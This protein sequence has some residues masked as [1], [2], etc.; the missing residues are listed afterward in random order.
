MPDSSPFNNRILLQNII[1]GLTVSFVA[2]SLGAAFGLLSGRGAFSG[3]LSAALIAS[4]TALFGGTRVQCS[5]PTGPMTAVTAVIFAAAH[6]QIPE[7]IPVL[8][9]DH[10]INITIILM[11]GLLFL[12]SILRLGKFI[13]FVPVVVVSGFM[14]G[15]ALII[16][17]DQIKKLFGLGG[18]A[19][20]SGPVSQNALLMVVSAAL[21]FLLPLLT[22]KFLPKLASYLSATIISIFVTTLF[23]YAV[24]F[25]VERVQLSTSLKGFSDITEL[26]SA[27]FPSTWSSTIIWYALPFA[28]QLALLCYLDTL[29]TSLVVDKMTEEKTRPNRELAAQGL[30]GF[31]VAFFGGIPG[32]QATIRSVLI[33]KEHATL[34]LAGVLVGVFALIEMILFQDA[35]NLIPQS[36]FAGILMKVGYDVFDWLPLRLYLKE[37]FRSPSVAVHGFFN[38]HDDK[39]I[40]ITNRE[41]L[42]ILGTSVVTIAWNLNAAVILFTAVFYVHNKLVNRNNPMRDLRPL[43]ETDVFRDTGSE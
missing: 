20:F 16:W 41:M 31:V 1:A 27:Q 9:P 26:V 36:V 10:F 18:K 28:F 40:F 14:N 15:I 8:N 24:G 34:R 35:I 25:D 11:A 29:L 30:A 23:A 37:V 22:R 38:R 6:D 19:A 3:M 33:V 32:A 4:I 17:F 12:F 13:Q 42:I 7:N 5:G 21:C 2:L 43:E 39:A